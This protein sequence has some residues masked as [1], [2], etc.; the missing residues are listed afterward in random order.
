MRLLSSTLQI[1][2]VVATTPSSPRVETFVRLSSVIF[3]VSHKGVGRPFAVA[4]LA[5][6]LALAGEAGVQSRTQGQL[7]LNPVGRTE[8][9]RR[10][11]VRHPGCQLELKAPHPTHQRRAAAVGPAPFR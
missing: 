3:R 11:R 7:S 8:R 4:R 1:A 10:G 6:P 5:Y 2:V 9:T